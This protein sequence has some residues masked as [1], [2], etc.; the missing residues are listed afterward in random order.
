ML[1]VIIADGQFYS[2]PHVP[3]DNQ[4]IIDIAEYEGAFVRVGNEHPHRFRPRHGLSGT[5]PF[6]YSPGLNLPIGLILPGRI[7]N[8]L[9]PKCQLTDGLS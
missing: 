6:T 8:I 4:F 2:K 7:Q 9:T 3:V 1:K 5:S